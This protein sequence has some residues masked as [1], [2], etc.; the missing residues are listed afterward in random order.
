MASLTQTG[1]VTFDGLPN[2]TSLSAAQAADAGVS[3]STFCNMLGARFV[4]RVPGAHN[5]TVTIPDGGN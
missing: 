3:E 1:V 2:Q 4:D 5:G